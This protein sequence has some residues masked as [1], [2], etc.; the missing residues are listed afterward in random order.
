VKEIPL[1]QGYV[2]IVDDED[3]DMLARHKWTAMVGG[4]N[5]TRIY[6]YRRTVF[7]SRTRRYK[8]P[9]IFLHRVIMN[10]PDGFYIDHINHDALDN[11]KENLR[12]C[13]PSQ[14]LANNR[15]PPGA[16]GYRGVTKTVNGEVAPYKAQIRGKGKS[17]LGTFFTIE[18]A[19]RAYDAEAIKRFGKFAKLN[20]PI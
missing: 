4:K 18:E 15:R 17:Y 12:I 5:F 13:T 10:P 2:A 1:S 9:T 16:C 6:A 19:A 7:D 8:G 3:Y 11:R 20:F 14:N